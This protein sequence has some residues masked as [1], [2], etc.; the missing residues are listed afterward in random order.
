MRRRYTMRARAAQLLERRDAILTAAYDLFMV[1]P[2]DQVSLV[3]VAQRA[4]VGTKTVLRAFG[5]KEALLAECARWG[6]SRES[7]IRAVPPGD[8]RAI[9]RTLA[10]RYEATMDAMR[11]YIDLEDRMPM[12]RGGLDRARTSHRDW[13]AAAFAPWLPSRSVTRARRLAAVFGAT[14]IYVWW[15]WR[16][17]L[18]MSPRLAEAAMLEMLEALVARWRRD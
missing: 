15:S 13:L 12:I 8:V 9:V 11:R 3:Q 17:R 14:E 1:T 16:R 10:A 5:S 4:G 7:M 6:T 2:F 18:G